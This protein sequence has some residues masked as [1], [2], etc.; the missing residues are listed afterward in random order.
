MFLWIVIV[1][2]VTVLISILLKFYGVIN[3]VLNIYDKGYKLSSDIDRILDECDAKNVRGLIEDVLLFVPVVNLVSAGVSNLIYKNNVFDN[4]KK[5]NILIEMNELEKRQYEN[6]NNKFQK[7][8][9]VTLMTNSNGNTI[10]QIINN[11]PTIV[12]LGLLSLDYDR[13][14]PLSY[15][16][17]EVKKLNSITKLNYKLGIVDGINIAII[18]LPGLDMEINRVQFK[19]ENYENKYMF[20]EMADDEN[21][22]FVIYPYCD[23]FDV[24]L[25]KG[26]E[27]I[28]NMRKN[29][30]IDNYK[31]LVSKRMESYNLVDEKG[32]V[33]K[34]VLKRKK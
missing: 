29:K 12:E 14:L 3:S 5:E 9:F 13:L 27:E 25:E 4:A 24:E 31:L 8:V 23:D 17:E 10:I 22:R 32:V 15:T 33:L 7:F 20:K 21:K 30:N 2:L 11:I 1:E 19:S 34:K 6:L 16:L 18:G 28:R 26:I